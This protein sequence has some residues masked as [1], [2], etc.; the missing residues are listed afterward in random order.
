[1]QRAGAR[2]GGPPIGI[3][4][5][6]HGRIAAEMVDTLTSVVG[7]LD[8]I[9]GVA[10]SPSDDGDA[11]RGRVLAAMARVDRGTGIVI[12]TDM[13]GDT[14]SNVA[15]EIARTRADVEMVAGVNMPMLMKVATD[16]SGVSAADLAD[17][18]RRYGRDHILWP[19]RGQ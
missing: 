6:G 2:D 10:C 5:V 14:A 11:V 4:V 1:M 15:L 18:I 3:V 13:L 8:A 19:G 16:R 17:L 7:R 12:F 9:E